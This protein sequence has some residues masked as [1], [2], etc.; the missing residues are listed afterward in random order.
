MGK[1][2]KEKILDFNMSIFL[3]LIG[4]GAIVVSIGFILQPDGTGVGMSVDLL[5]KFAF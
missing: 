5:K 4:I 1:M 3:S 2:R